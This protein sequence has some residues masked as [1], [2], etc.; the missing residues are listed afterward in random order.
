MVAEWIG[1]QI[2][3]LIRWGLGTMMATVLVVA[4]LATLAVFSRVVDLR[5]VFGSG[6]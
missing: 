1:L 5:R 2:L 6:A 4:I 3:D